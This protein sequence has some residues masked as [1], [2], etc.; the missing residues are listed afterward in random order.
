MSDKRAALE[1]LP[2]MTLL[3]PDLKNLV[4]D[5]F[6]PA[7]FSFGGNIVNEGEQTDAVYVL[8]EGRARMI[9]RD[10]NGEE[11]ALSALKPGETFGA[12]G[13]LD[14]SAIGKRSTTVR[15]SSDVRAY[16]LDPALFQALL[17]NHPEIKKYFEM[18]QRH[19]E[20][21]N[22]IK[23]YTIFAKLPAEALKPLAL[24]AETITA[25][26]GDVVIREG[27]PVG[28][29][30]IVE[31]GRLRAFGQDGQR[32]RDLAFLRKG[33][34]FGEISIA[35]NQPRR[36]T[37]EAITDCRLI[38]INETTFGKLYAGYPE[39]RA[40]IEERIAQYEYK[41]TA[42]LPLDFAE[43]ILPANA[44]PPEQVGAR[45]LDELRTDMS[46]GPFATT[47]GHF[48]KTGK[49]IRRFQHIRQIDEMD[50]GAA[51]LAMVCRYFGRK[52]SITRIRQVVN[53]AT[54]GTSL[55]GLC[56]GAEALG[57]AARSVKA[58]KSNVGQ[59]P[60][61]A[62]IHWEN[63]HWVVLFDVNETSA[64]IADPAT[65]VRKI[66]RKELDEKWNGYA[67]LFDYAE[68][69]E[70]APESS[71]GFGW[72]TP[73][74][75]P[76]TGIFAKA[77]GLAVIVSALQ[78]LLPVF[79][80]VIVDSVLVENDSGLLAMMIGSM[81]VVLIFM[82]VAM[83]VQRYLL[84]F[85]AVRIDSSTLDFI[86]RRLLALPISYFAARKTGDI[87]RRILG[88]RQ[89]RE[90]L[91]QNGV[92]GLTAVAQIAAAITLMVVYSPTLAVVFAA[93]APLY[94]G[95]MRFSSKRL[96]PMFDELEEAYGKYNSRQ[97]DAIKGIETVKAL[98]AESGLREKMLNEFHD[99]A[100]KQFKSSF[101]MMGYEG[102][103]QTVGFLSMAMFLF[104]A[105]HRVM[106]GEMTIGAMVAFNSLVAM[107]NAPILTLLSMW[108]NWQL[109]AVLL[110]RMNDIFESEPEQGYDHSHLKP[111]R[112]LEGRVRLWNVTFQYGGPDSARILEGVSIDIPAGKTVAIVG[113]SGSGKT[114]LVKCLAGMLEPTE[115]SI[116]FDGVEQRKL[117]Y[118]DLRRQIGFVLQ[119]NYLFD[120]TIA[121]NIAFGEDDPDPERVA[122]AAR[123]ANAHEF[124]E[125]LPLGYDTRVG[126]TGIALSGGQRQ[127]IAIARAVYNKPPILIFDEATSALDTESEK[128]V[129]ENMDQLFNGRTSFVI[130]HRLSTIRDADLI[131]VI[132]KGRI[133]EQG[134]H[135]ELMGR[136]GLYYYLS[137]Q[138]LG[139]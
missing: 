22:F 126:E 32:R 98:G 60:L 70:Q 26:E 73:F 3:P 48:V 61:P 97:I 25:G 130:A 69:F 90:F 116:F 75:K 11:I 50:C 121:K 129:K 71:A 72:L 54:D 137:S 94:A 19:R 33:D 88:V 136:Q 103:V 123:V 34:L 40:K 77:F 84:S 27:D 100:H 74:L 93:V 28:P 53:T 47:D 39:F 105:A 52:V 2:M 58:S 38:R 108:D 43:E 118:R 46:L 5:C 111:V 125:R 80:Q 17:Q 64:W 49:R 99:L 44:A 95:L 119:E 133:V 117:R 55:R 31:D 114:T 113:R 30:F 138:Q 96:R 29:M 83:L 9:K 1:E 109:A 134:S 56:R 89:V 102:A 76:F 35:K 128:A 82:A 14:P 86:A 4:M 45:Q 78:M 42:R 85:V 59:M 13:L 131:L 24:E 79:T 51:S 120:D 6:I 20:I 127:R 115:G 41:K 122:W 21:T 68:A 65:S 8:A 132:E 67:A 110:D 12:T 57:L 10:A 87:Q 107:A 16:K 106:D 112:T 37:V 101:L 135:D 92:N 91:V 62:I 104:V 36:A 7:S 139:L 15:A 124:I 66:T 18:E 23:L 81:V 63:Y